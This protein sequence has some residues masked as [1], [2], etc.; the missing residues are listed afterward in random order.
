MASTPISVERMLGRLPKSAP[1]GRHLRKLRIFAS[2]PSVRLSAGQVT[3]LEIPYEPL[4]ETFAGQ[5]LQVIGNGRPFDASGQRLLNLDD[6]IVAMTSGLTPT[7]GNPQFLQ[8]MVYAVTSWTL[9]RFATALGRQPEFAFDGPLLLQPYCMEEVN[10]YYDRAGGSLRFGWFAA[11]SGALGADQRGSLTFTAAAHDIVIHEATH[12]LLDGL[13]PHLLVP[14][15]PDVLAFHEGF[16][17]LVAIFAR[18]THGSLLEKAIARGKGDI[19][20]EVLTAVGRQFGRVTDHQGPLRSSTLDPAEYESERPAPINYG[21]TMLPHTR[22]SLLLSAVFEAYRTVYHRKTLA[23]RSVAATVPT[24]AEHPVLIA[25]LTRTAQKLAAQFLNII[26]RAIDYL[27]PVDIHYGDYLRAMI[28]ADADL[29]PSDDWNYREALIYAFRRYGIEVRHVV[30]LSESTL[31]WLPPDAA[32]G[33]D[34]TALARLARLPIGA[35]G[36]VGQTIRR[37]RAAILQ[38][39][40]RD[41]EKSWSALGLAT[42]DPGEAPQRVSV[43]SVRAIRRI[44]PD[45]NLMVNYVAEVLAWRHV[46]GVGWF[47]G[48]STLVIEPDGNLCYLIYKRLASDG[49]LERTR[50]YLNGPGLR[51]AHA[52]AAATNPDQVGQ[53]AAGLLSALHRPCC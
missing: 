42:A 15:N 18:F 43:E 2:D 41:N 12:A 45:G 51:Y 39:F 53:L 22:G 7:A 50:A 5:R 26:I 21:N 11:G 3:T 46:Q 33:L 9:G 27:P 37:R 25:A 10:A 1:E 28:T 4:D 49:R 24:L 6:P 32:C 14:T 17:D 31:R 23:W 38:R 29:V 36:A 48:G 20:D 44:G 30:D 34:T 13:R 52:L 19:N 8:Q 40:L 35:D 47:P 16:A